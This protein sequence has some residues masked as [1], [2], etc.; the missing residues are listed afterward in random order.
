MHNQA[1]VQEMGWKF[2]AYNQQLLFK[3]AEERAR[4]AYEKKLETL[5]GLSVEQL[6]DLA[7][8]ATNAA[9]QA[10]EKEAQ[11]RGKHL[12]DAGFVSGC[13]YT[14]DTVSGELLVGDKANTIAGR[15]LCEPSAL[16]ERL[17]GIFA[18]LGKVEKHRLLEIMK[19]I[20]DAGAYK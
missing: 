18:G 16:S 1:A 12:V 3:Q 11:E 8:R 15:T 20:Y 10:R 19:N 2:S 13:W 6:E 4:M 9:K 17:V 5:D 14:F 7:K